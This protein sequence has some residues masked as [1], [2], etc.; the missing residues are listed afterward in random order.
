MCSLLIVFQFL[1]TQF[2]NQFLGSNQLLFSGFHVFQGH[3]A[4]VHFIFSNQR[5]KRDHLGIGITHLLLHFAGIGEDFSTNTCCPYLGKYIHRKS[6]L[7]LTKVDKQKLR[8]VH[9]FLRIQ[10]Q[11][12]SAHRICGLHQTKY[13]LRRHLPYRRHQ[14]GCH[15][16]RRL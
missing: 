14:S 7:F 11:A 12:G 2:A 8:T 1:L 5:N 3:F 9:S 15:N 6:R 16:G 4:L 10:F 13:P